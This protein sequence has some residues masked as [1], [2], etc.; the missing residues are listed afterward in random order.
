MEVKSPF[1]YVNSINGASKKSIMVD[2]S[3]RKQYLPFIINRT[4]SYHQ[5]TVLFA[6]E[7]NLNSHL[8]EMM[9]YDFLRLLIRPKKRFAKWAKPLPAP[10][11]LNLLMK[12]Y[13]CNRTKAQEALSIISQDELSRI[14]SRQFCGGVQ[15]SK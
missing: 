1:D 4:L 5:D 2:E 8:P 13:S 12:E 3:D 6:N 10:D 15:K 11:D 9:Q 7:M 14:R